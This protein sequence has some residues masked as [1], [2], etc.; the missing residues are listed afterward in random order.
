[1]QN[2]LFEWDDVKAQTNKAKHRISFEAAIRIFDVDATIDDPDLTMDYGEDRFRAIGMVNGVVIAVSY[3]MRGL[4][5]RIISARK[6]TRTEEQD[7]AE[8]NR[9]S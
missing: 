6:A 7:Y 1:M 8:Q 9:T 4:R 2:E 3:T 5:R